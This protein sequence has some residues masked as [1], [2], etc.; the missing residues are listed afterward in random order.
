MY[1]VLSQGVIELVV[2]T[3][4]KKVI[5]NFNNSELGVPQHKRLA[6]CLE[7]QP[8]ESERNRLEDMSVWKWGENETNLVPTPDLRE[9]TK[10][11]YGSINNSTT[12]LQ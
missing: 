7:T 9:F 12:V 2:N 1:S 4:V 3:I 5:D 8:I 11:I 6:H 10:W